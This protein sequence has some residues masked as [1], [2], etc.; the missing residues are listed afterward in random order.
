[1]NEGT[2]LE[3]GCTHHETVLTTDLFGKR[4]YHKSPEE[5]A[6]LETGDNVGRIKVHCGGALANKTEI[7]LERW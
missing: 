7:S 6:T 2:Y 1:M 5:T 3:N 4:K